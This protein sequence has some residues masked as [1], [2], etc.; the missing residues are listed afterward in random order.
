MWM[1]VN[2][3]CRQRVSD[4]VHKIEALPSY[5][6]VRNYSVE[7]RIHAFRLSAPTGRVILINTVSHIL[8]HALKKPNKLQS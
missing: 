3:K 4:V 8:V 7:I 1:N 5:S 2:H 6:V